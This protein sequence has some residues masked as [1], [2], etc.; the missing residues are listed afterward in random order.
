M[1]ASPHCI[2]ACRPARP[3]INTAA[4]WISLAK[5]IASISPAS[6]FSDLIERVG[7]LYKSP[8]RKGLCPFAHRRRSVRVLKL[9]E[10]S[11]RDDCLPEKLRKHS[12]DTAQNEIVQRRSVRDDNAHERGKSLPSAALSVSRS[13]A[14]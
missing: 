3:A 5:E 14:E 8:G 1:N 2:A 12:F 4:A 9:R 7:F 11:W 10:D 13:S 6:T